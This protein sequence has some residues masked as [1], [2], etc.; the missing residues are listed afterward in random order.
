[1]LGD[2]RLSKQFRNVVKVLGVAVAVYLALTIKIW[3]TWETDEVTQFDYLANETKSE[4]NMELDE[5]ESHWTSSAFSKLCSNYKSICNKITR[6]SQIT[7][8]EKVIDFAYVIYLLKK[9]DANITRWKDP[10]QALLAMLI[11]EKKWSRRGSANRDTIT[12]NLWWIDYD[13]EFFQ[14][15]SHEMW[16]IVDLGWLQW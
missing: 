7:E 2:T 10:S 11:N 15:I 16:H 9:L 6:S 5:A 1:M 14:I 13:S 4:E 8:D 12:I 3:L